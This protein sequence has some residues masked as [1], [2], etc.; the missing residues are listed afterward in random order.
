MIELEAITEL[1]QRLSA[2]KDECIYINEEEL[3]QWP[4]ET[5]Q[6]MKSQKLISKA[7]PASS[8]IC[9]GCERNC[10]MPV[11]SVKGVQNEVTTFIVCDKPVRI[12]RVPV[13]LAQL[14][15]WQ[16][17][18]N[19]V[20]KFIV[21]CLSLRLLNKKIP[22][23]HLIEIGMVTGKKRTQML[24]LN[25]IA[26]IS[27]QAG[28]ISIPLT[29]IIEFNDSKYLL[30]KTIIDQ[31]V[32]TSSATDGRY[33]PSSSRQDLRKQNTQRRNAIWQ[34]EY[35]KIK[36]EQPNKSDRQIAKQI[37]DSSLGKGCREGTIRNL[38]KS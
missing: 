8:A 1:L 16:I 20:I 13:S 33:T 10:T 6:A 30:N 7:P 29:E 38:M 3:D 15:Q 17:S 32:D 36:K 9:S 12:G 26:E 14:N 28:S 5:I 21:D 2:L 19:S 22:E 27:L 37:A 34:K 23:K 24:C 4:F 31:M 18:L 11:Y 35:R 25:H